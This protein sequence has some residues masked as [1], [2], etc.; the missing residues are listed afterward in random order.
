MHTITYCVTHG[1]EHDGQPERGACFSE[2]WSVVPGEVVAEGM[3]EVDT[4]SPFVLKAG[5]LAYLDSPAAG[6]VPV[7][8]L[9]VDGGGVVKVRVTATRLAYQRGLILNLRNPV[10]FLLPRTATWVKGGRRVRDTDSPVR[11]YTDAGVLL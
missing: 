2:E 11:L 5:D 1:H 6:F 10:M 3:V 7:K 8:L 9:T 4:R